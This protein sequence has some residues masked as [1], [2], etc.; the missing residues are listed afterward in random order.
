MDPIVL[1]LI[2][3]IPGL[4][5][6][7][8]GA[9]QGIK[10]NQLGKT[11]QPMMEIPDSITNMLKTSENLAGQRGAPGSDI[12]R[13][14]ISSDVA[15]TMDQVANI[16]GGS[17]SALAGLSN[18]FTAEQQALQNV[19][20][21]DQQFYQQNQAQL[22]EAL[23]TMGG[24]EQTQWNTN[25]K[26][27]FDKIMQTSAALKGAGMENMFG[28]IG[29][30]VG[31]GLGGYMYGE[32][33]FGSNPPKMPVDIESLITKLPESMSLSDEMGWPDMMNPGAGVMA[34]QIQVGTNTVLDPTMPWQQWIQSMIPG[35][36]NMSQGSK[37]GQP[38][39]QWQDWLKSILPMIQNGYT[40]SQHLLYK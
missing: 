20:V 34:P 33:K 23:K 38:N 24:W 35:L 16:Q 8:V 3:M 15:A 28:G 9:F 31:A 27:P 19:D 5:Q 39:G 1:M 29:S 7:G 22:M 37:D 36:P 26:D 30:M 11:D 25:V 40:P 4:I 18:L 13:D 12:A 10:G 21:N 6:T 14:R 32:D 17:G 2:S